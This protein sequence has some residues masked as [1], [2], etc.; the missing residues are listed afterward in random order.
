MVSY[1]IQQGK[2]IVFVE[3]RLEESHWECGREGAE[4]AAERGPVAFDFRLQVLPV[5][6]QR[7]VDAQSVQTAQHLVGRHHDFIHCKTGA[8]LRRG[9]Q[10]GIRRG[11]SL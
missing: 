9:Y 7:R 3:V 2:R 8:E 10:V 6:M 4:A 5:A 11:T 1:P